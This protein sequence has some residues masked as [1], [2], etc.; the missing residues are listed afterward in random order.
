MKGLGSTLLAAAAILMYLLAL[1]SIMT[2]IGSWRGTQLA[3]QRRLGRASAA[4]LKQNAER[5]LLLKVW[6][7]VLFVSGATALAG[8]LLM[9]LAG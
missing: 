2:T 4:D 8:G 6:R 7:P 3:K 1:L 5:R 9:L